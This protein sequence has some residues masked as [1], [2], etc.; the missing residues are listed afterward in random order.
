ME[1]I[2]AVH[3]N[4]VPSNIVPSNIVPSNIVPSK[5][6]VVPYRNRYHQKFFFSTQMTSILKNKNDYVILFAHQ[7]DERSFNRGAMKNIGFIAMKEKYPNDYKNMNFI[8]NDVDTLPFTYIFDYETQEGI[9]KHYY[10]FED[11]LG[12][13]VVIKGCDF[14]KI[15]GYPN[16]WGWGM[17]DASLQ[18]RCNKHGL[19]IDRTNFYTVG[20]PEILQLFDGVSRLISK[21]DHT[22]MLLDNGRDGIRT[23]H[24]LKYT[25]DSESSNPED[26]NH[27]ISND[28][29]KYVNV[30]DFQSLVRFEKEG[31]FDYDLRQPK[32]NI[33][34]SQN[35]QLTNKRVSTTNE[36]QNIPYYP[37]IQERKAEQYRQ[38]QVNAQIHNSLSREQIPMNTP[39]GIY[40]QQYARL[41]GAK[42]RASSNL[43]IGLGGLKY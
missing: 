2:D 16:F 43:S 17:E 27:V 5:V 25:I 26:N 22:R 28:K 41:V 13:I 23:I 40:S 31:F 39:T 1:N 34:Y 10:G 3:S 21:K 8:F 24:K 35:A 12:G 32:E 7:S 6:F 38:S 11:A 29:I 4:C 19:T 15:N 37:T 18:K 42:S 30:K 9:I 36:W 33:I 20:S 14:E